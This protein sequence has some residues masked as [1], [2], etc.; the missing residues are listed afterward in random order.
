MKLRDFFDLALQSHVSLLQILN[1]LMLHFVH[2]D[3]F[4]NL[5]VVR[6][7]KAVVISRHGFQSIEERMLLSRIVFLHSALRLILKP[8]LN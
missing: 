3:D 1:V 2:I 4:E 6:K 7:N 8:V 5:R